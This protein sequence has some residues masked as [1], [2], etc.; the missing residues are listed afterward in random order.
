[1][2][3]SELFGMA[4]A[5]IIIGAIGI[6]SV[7]IF[8]EHRG[9]S[10]EQRVTTDNP[11]W[12]QVTQAQAE[13]DYWDVGKPEDRERTEDGC[14]GK[15]V[16]AAYLIGASAAVLGVVAYGVWMRFKRKKRQN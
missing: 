7:H 1:M 5:L 12:S 14:A 3:S 15:I 16:A 6:W 2:K 13:A 11:H 4:L 8:G 9:P 10:D